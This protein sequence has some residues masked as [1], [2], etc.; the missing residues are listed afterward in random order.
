MG[1]NGWWTRDEILYGIADCRPRLIVGARKRLARVDAVELRA[2]VIEIESDFDQLAGDSDVAL[3]SV[4]IDEDDPA[5]ILYTS[6]TTGR[7]KG[8][9]NSHRAILGFVSLVFFHGLRS[10]M[11]AAAKVA[12]ANTDEFPDCRL[13]CVEGSRQE[14]RQELG[15]QCQVARG[16]QESRPLARR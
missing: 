7:P 2:P 8:A 14:G 4:P 11:L 9:V 16:V 15:A 1:L 5:V 12:H 10:R 6:G 3:P 13:Q